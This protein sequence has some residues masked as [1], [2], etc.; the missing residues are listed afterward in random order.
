M[1]AMTPTAKRQLLQALLAT[2][3]ALSSQ[4]LD[5]SGF[6]TIPN[7]KNDE[8]SMDSTSKKPEFD[9]GEN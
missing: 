9:A 3:S 4:S 6:N 2:S 8:T 5:N 1:G 7:Q